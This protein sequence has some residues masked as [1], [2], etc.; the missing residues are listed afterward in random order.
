MRHSCGI[1]S[2]SFEEMDYKEIPSG[3]NPEG[4]VMFRET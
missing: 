2:S 4:I 1:R 3:N